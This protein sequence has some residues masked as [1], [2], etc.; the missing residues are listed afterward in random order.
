MYESNPIKN[1]V[2]TWWYL[3][4]FKTSTTAEIIGKIMSHA[5]LEWWNKSC[6]RTKYAKNLVLTYS[7]VSA[8]V[9][10][11]ATTTTTATAAAESNA[12]TR[13]CVRASFFFFP[14]RFIH[15]VL[16]YWLTS[17][18]GERVTFIRR[19]PRFPRALATNYEY[20][21]VGTLPNS[22]PRA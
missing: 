17:P 7:F 16:I 4:Q 19:S 6:R 11:A 20:I 13:I 15:A 10:T 22:R 5:K 18:A 2:Q 9:P 14:L 8:H 3:P 12:I 1:H 21:R